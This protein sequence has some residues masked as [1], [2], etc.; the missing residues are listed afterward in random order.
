M[1]APLDG[2]L[3]NNT[4]IDLQWTAPDNGGSPITSYVVYWNQGI[5]NT[6]PIPYVEL[7]G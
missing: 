5:N 3:T 6:T 4:Y 2:P 7:I 1:A